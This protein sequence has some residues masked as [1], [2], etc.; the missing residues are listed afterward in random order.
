MSS[1]KAAHL[2]QFQDE[3]RFRSA[4]SPGIVLTVKGDCSNKLQMSQVHGSQLVHTLVLS[5]LKG[6]VI[7]SEQACLWDQNWCLDCLRMEHDVVKQE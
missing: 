7:V 6:L 2:Y 5:M 4:G 3:V 1:S